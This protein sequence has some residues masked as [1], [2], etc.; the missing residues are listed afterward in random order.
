MPARPGPRSTS[1]PAWPGER[2]TPVRRAELVTPFRYGAAMDTNDL[3]GISTV[4]GS[5]D[6]AIAN[7]ASA[8]LGPMV[9][10]TG[11]A[12]PCRIC[13]VALAA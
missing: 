8:G 5:L 4:P 1:P 7:L 6:A 11:A 2:S 10:V 13:P 3:S 12:D 9:V